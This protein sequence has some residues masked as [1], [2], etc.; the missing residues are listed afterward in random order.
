VAGIYYSPEGEELFTEIEI[1][2]PGDVAS[3]SFSREIIGLLFGAPKSG[4][5]E[6]ELWTMPS[7]I[8]QLTYS[9]Q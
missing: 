3:F 2:K 5:A 9:A 7:F 4:C 1:L 6:E 8:A